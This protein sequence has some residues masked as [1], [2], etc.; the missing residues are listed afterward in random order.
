MS[1]G[2]PTVPLDRLASDGWVEVERAT[3]T[4]FDARFVAV[5]AHSVVYEDRTLRARVREATGL[6]GG[7]R[8]FLA[9]RLVLRPVAADSGPVRRLVAGRALDG[10][11]DALTELGFLGVRR[12]R[13]A[14]AERALR[15]PDGRRADVNVTGYLAVRSAGRRC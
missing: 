8:V 13:D 10:F 7:W 2:P 14:D 9:T 12:T 1:V 11:G 15:H 5:D 3:R 6:D 4:P